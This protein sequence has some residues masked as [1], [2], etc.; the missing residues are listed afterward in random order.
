M[1]ASQVRACQE[2]APLFSIPFAPIPGNLG[3]VKI[4]RGKLRLRQ[5]REHAGHTSLLK[6]LAFLKATWRIG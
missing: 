4:R 3:A 6:K 2:K 1:P 5:R